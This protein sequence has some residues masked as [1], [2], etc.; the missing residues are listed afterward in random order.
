MAYAIGQRNLKEC[1]RLV[2]LMERK[3]IFDKLKQRRGIITHMYQ[4]MP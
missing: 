1:E 4:K 2:F 3:Q